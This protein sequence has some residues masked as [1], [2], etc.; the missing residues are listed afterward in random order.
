[1]PVV[2]SSWLMIS[3]FFLY[4]GIG[5]KILFI[6]T[7]IFYAIFFGFIFFWSEAKR[8]FLIVPLL[9]TFEFFLAGFMIVVIISLLIDV[10][11]RT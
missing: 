4:F 1:M 9:Y 10:F 5:I 3:M 6:L 2:G 11:V 7:V 8:T